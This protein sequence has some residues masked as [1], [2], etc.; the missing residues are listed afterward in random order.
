MNVRRAPRTGLG[1]PLLLLLPCHL[2]IEAQFS[3]TVFTALFLG[4]GDQLGLITVT[5]LTVAAGIAPLL[6]LHLHDHL[7]LLTLGL[8]PL[9]LQCRLERLL[10]LLARRRILTVVAAINRQP[11]WRQLDN[12]IHVFQKA[13]VV[14]DQHQA[15]RPAIDLLRELVLLINIQVVAGF[16][17][18]EPVGSGEPCPE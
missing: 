14:T 3:L 16:I 4:V 12:F 15:V 8:R 11:Q 18:N 17:E 5:G 1:D 6:T 10:L 7:T 2:L 9:P 13:S